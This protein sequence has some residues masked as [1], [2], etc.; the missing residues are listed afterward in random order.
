[1]Q[2]FERAKFEIKNYSETENFGKFVIEPLE[3]GFGTTIG[4]AL[5]RV[6]LSSLPGGAVYSIKIDNIYHEFT[7]IPGVKEDVTMIILNVKGLILDINPSDDNVYTLRINKQGP[8]VITGADIECGSEVKILNPDHVICNLAE[9]A[10]FEC[11][12]KAKI[13]RG[14]VSSDEN[15][16]IYQTSAQGIGTIYTDAIYTPVTKCNF[17][18]EPTRVG[19]STKYD[20]LT[21]EVTTDGSITPQE[22]IALASKI[23]MNH[24]ELLTEV[25]AIG[26][27]NESII[28]DSTSETNNNKTNM[29]IED[30]DLS[31]RSYNC[32]KRAG[33]ATVEELIQKSEDEMGKV[34][35]LGKKS[36]K[37]IRDK[38]YEIG[39]SFKKD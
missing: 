34:R 21:I 18:S 30:L 13:G 33:I 24:L 32:L 12:M 23:L 29:M 19:E 11:E 15:K 6:M 27:D 37:E 25:D 35:N 7:S 22:S 20:K 9:G 4:N 2:K 14:Y 1:M 5:R 38:I 8:C 16:Y 17:Y 31:V 36:L 26:L 3:R 28:K 10:K 39:L